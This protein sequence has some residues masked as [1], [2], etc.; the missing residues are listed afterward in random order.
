MKDRMHSRFSSSVVS[1]AFFFDSLPPIESKELRRESRHAISE[2]SP[3][4]LM[5]A[6]FFKVATHSIRPRHTMKEE[7]EEERGTRRRE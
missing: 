2:K 5:A 4:D 1:R 3:D 6:R 7:G